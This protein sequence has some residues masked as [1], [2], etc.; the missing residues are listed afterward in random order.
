M[1]WRHSFVAGAVLETHG[2]E[3]H[4]AVSSALTFRRIANTSKL[5]DGSQ[6]FGTQT[7]HAA[8]QSP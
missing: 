2:G 1:T 8:R 5:E 4:E 7:E 6:N 3:W